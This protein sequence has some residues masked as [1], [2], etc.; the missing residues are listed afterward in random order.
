MGYDYNHDPQ[1]NHHEQHVA[2]MSLAVTGELPH[3]KYWDHLR[4]Q[5]DAHPFRFDHNH[6][7]L[8]MLMDRDLGQR[9]GLLGSDAP[10]FHEGHFLSLIDYRHDLHPHNFDHYHPFL[11]PLLELKLPHLGGMPGIPG[12]PG[13]PGGPVVGIP[14]PP[15][16]PVGG[17]PGV[18]PE[19]PSILLFG[20]GFLFLGIIAVVKKRRQKTGDPGGCLSAS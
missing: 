20:L 12:M 19:P 14:G 11:G 15:G 3:D 6:T 2:L 10:L 8:G 1:P 13:E 7:T 16:G 17:G 4:I 5:H 9:E 18:V